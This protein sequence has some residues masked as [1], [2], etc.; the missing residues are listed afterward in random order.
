MTYKLICF[1]LDGTL[2]DDTKSIWSTIHKA[3]GTDNEQ[4][5]RVMKQFFDGEIS[6]D[7]WAKHDIMLWKGVRLGRNKLLEIFGSLKMM[8][9]AKETIHELKRRGYKLAVVSGSIDLVID[10]LFPEHPFDYVFINK[11]VFEG[12]N[13]IGVDST[14]YDTE[15]KAEAL[16]LICNKEGISLDETIFVGDH[17]NDVEIARLAGYSIAFNCIS[18]PLKEVCDICI[19]KKDVKEI[20]KEIDNIIDREIR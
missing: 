5:R 10:T 1:D 12:D 20:L 17:D 2:V 18:E 15:H 7:E 11:L 3:V 9:G 19:E 16:R 14:Q 6:Y 4:R 13:L 8:P